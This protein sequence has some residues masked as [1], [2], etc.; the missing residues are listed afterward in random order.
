[1]MRKHN[2]VRRWMMPLLFAFALLSMAG[3][4]TSA[5]TTSNPKDAGLLP[6]TQCSEGPIVAQNL[7]SHLKPGPTCAQLVEKFPA[8]NA[9]ESPDDKKVICPFLRLLKR[10]G[11]LDKEIENN[12]SIA[13]DEKSV[14]PVSLAHLELV[15]GEIGCEGKACVAVAASVAKNQNSLSPPQ[16]DIGRLFAAPTR[17]SYSNQSQDRA[18]HDCGYTFQFGD[19]AVNDETRTATL[20]RFKEIADKNAG[21]ISIADLVAVKKESCQR[22]YK[23]YKAKGLLPFNLVDE[24]K[25]T[26][27]PDSRDQ[28]EVALIYAYLGGVD[29]GYLTYEDLSNFFYAKIAPNKTRFLL[30]F[31]LLGIAQAAHQGLW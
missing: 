1:M 22:D 16:V 27:I 2:A 26:L 9:P 15:T 7:P 5:G 31:P 18:S 21:R 24:A 23:I 6:M 25:Q 11:L 10:T 13:S 28:M 20:Q 3:C 17:A 14:A 12:L 30:D 4:R 29:N 19:E 8:A